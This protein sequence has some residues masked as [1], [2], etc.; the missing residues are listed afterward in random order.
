MKISIENSNNVKIITLNVEK[1]DVVNMQEIKKA[2]DAEIK[3]NP[4]DVLI[5]FSNVSFVDSSGL[6]VIV[7]VFKQLNGLEHKLELCGLQAQPM[8][9]LEITQ[10]HKIF[11]IVDS[12]NA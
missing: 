1:F 7:S 11:T 10:L 8:E 5:N 12:C 9:L 2:I 3:N 6:S 4:S